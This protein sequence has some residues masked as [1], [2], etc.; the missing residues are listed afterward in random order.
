M[1]GAIALRAAA[2]LCAGGVVITLIVLAVYVTVE[3]AGWPGGLG[4]LAGILALGG[5]GLW[6][7][8][9]AISS[10]RRRNEAMVEAA[11]A[12]ARA[13][14]G[15]PPESEPREACGAR[16]F[17][18]LGP[19]IRLGSAG[20]PLITAL[21]AVEGPVKLVRLGLRA[22]T[23]WKAYQAVKERTDRAEAAE[24]SRERE[25]VAQ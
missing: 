3:R 19:W 13:E 1:L 5:L 16:P 23:A 9:S 24:A 17:E 4:V 8:G 21:I 10:R 7:T 25:H 2:A 18:N 15:M 11:R 22:V 12:Q 14:L 6:V 20:L